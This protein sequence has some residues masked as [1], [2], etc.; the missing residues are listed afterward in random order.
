MGS[1]SVASSI[2]SLV[3]LKTNEKYAINVKIA[4]AFLIFLVVKDA[5]NKIR[6]LMFFKLLSEKAR[7]V[8]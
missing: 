6:F 4:T 8:K 2:I 7:K 1:L 3:S 5:S